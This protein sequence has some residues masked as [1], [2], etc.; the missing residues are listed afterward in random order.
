MTAPAGRPWADGRAR[1]GAGPTGRG[2]VTTTADRA[3]ISAA[4]RTTPAASSRAR[5]ALTRGLPRPHRWS[6]V[7]AAG[8][9]WRRGGVARCA[10]SRV[11]ARR[12]GSPTTRSRP[13]DPRGDRSGPLALTPSGGVPASPHR[14]RGQ[15]PLAAGSAPDAGRR[16]RD[17][18]RLGGSATTSRPWPCSQTRSS[19]GGRPQHAWRRRSPGEAASPVGSSCKTCWPTWVRGRARCSSTATSPG[20]SDRTG[21]RPLGVR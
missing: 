10:V 5:R 2:G 3:R 13:A 9:V 6:D 7:A 14:P 12:G 8:V 16:G 1:G 18:R 21:C 19:P 4:R 20:S 15:G 17:R 11:G